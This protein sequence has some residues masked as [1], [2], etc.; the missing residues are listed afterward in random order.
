MADLLHDLRKLDPDSYEAYECV[1]LKYALSLAEIVANDRRTRMTFEEFEQ[2]PDTLEYHA[3]FVEP[4]HWSFYGVFNE[5]HLASV[6]DRIAARLQAFVQ[7]RE[8]GRITIEGNAILVRGKADSVLLA[9]LIEA[10]REKVEE[11][12]AQGAHVWHLYVFSADAWIYQN[13]QKQIVAGAIPFEDPEVLPG[14]K[15]TL[16]EIFQGPGAEEE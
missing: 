8:L 11:Y 6:R 16:S 7:T 4:K 14:F 12:L 15:L 3:G 9:V 10:S 2:L 13:T 1:I 5:R